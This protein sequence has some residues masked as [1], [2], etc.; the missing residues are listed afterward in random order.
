MI[1]YLLVK[2]FSSDVPEESEMFTPVYSLEIPSAD[3]AGTETIPVSFIEGRKEEFLGVIPRLFDDD[4]DMSPTLNSTPS[5]ME[6][7]P[8]Y[9]P[10]SMTGNFKK[11]FIP[12]RSIFLLQVFLFLCQRKSKRT[13]LHSP[14]RKGWRM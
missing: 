7:S 3:M 4:E 2:G 14:W 5:N 8:D 9:T 1:P 6:P 12:V 13:S 11:S 10:P